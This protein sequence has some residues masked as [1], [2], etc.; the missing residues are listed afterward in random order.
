MLT[1]DFEKL[2]T[3]VLSKMQAI[4]VELMT[5]G[6]TAEALIPWVAERHEEAGLHPVI[7]LKESTGFIFNRIWAAIKREV[8]NVLSEGVATPATIDGVWVE[9][10]GSKVGPCAM[11]G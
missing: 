2:V 4:I 1:A 8:M 6:H 3:R 10:Y 11:M 9:M 7:A 5:S